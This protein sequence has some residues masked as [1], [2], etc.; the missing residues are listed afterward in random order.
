MAI[1]TAE[2]IILIIQIV[3]LFFVGYLFLLTVMA[4]FAARTSPDRTAGQW[5]HFAF[6]IPAHNEEQ[7]LPDL[8]KSIRQADYPA[9]QFDIHVIADNCEDRTAEIA[10]AY[11]AKVHLRFNKTLIGKPYA[12]QWG[13]QEI[14]A[15]GLQ[16][17]AYIIVDADST[18][19]ANFL[20]V[21][22]RQLCSGANVIQAY[23]GVR[24]PELSWNIGLRY[25]AL[26]VLH[27]LRP[28]GRMVLGGSAGLKGNGMIFTQDILARFPWPAS[29]TEDIEYH[30]MLLLNGY[31][32]KF[33]PDASVWGEMPVKFDQSQ[34]Q[35]DRW[36]YGRVEMARKYV[37]QLL[38]AAGA[39]AAKGKIQRAFACLDAAMEHLIPPFSL[40]FSATF[41]IL[42]VDL[43][44]LLI[45]QRFPGATLSAGL[46]WVNAAIGLFLIA[47]QG[48]YLL[49]GLIMVRAP[50]V[51]YK[52]LLFVPVF[53]I[54]KIGQYIKLRFGKKQLSWVKTERNQ[55]PKAASK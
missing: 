25:A 54:R 44:L 52:Q 55:G 27:F 8:L 47:A 29:V 9:G 28:Q 37:P 53:V 41:L 34:S 20:Q 23:Y 22:N 24:D 11:G 40:L 45:S 4:L 2:V 39:A 5:K 36:E 48:I 17:D 16:Y 7:L 19:S 6:L 46:S 30:M 33:A 35:L 12:L 31:T 32:V 49:S 1:F 50:L 13:F 15:S 38:K 26:V 42:F 18:I 51:I 10:A 21:M 3:G 14:Q 43:A